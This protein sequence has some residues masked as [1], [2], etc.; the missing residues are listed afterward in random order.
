ALDLARGATLHAR[1]HGSDGSVL[2]ASVACPRG[3]VRAGA[4]ERAARSQRSR[5][6]VRRQRRDVALRPPRTW[7]G[8]RQFRAAD[9]DLTPGA[10]LRGA[11]A[12]LA[13]LISNLVC[14]A[15]LAGPGSDD[16]ATDGLDEVGVADLGATFVGDHHA[17]LPPQR[18]DLRRQ[19]EA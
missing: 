10:I 16:A 18:M 19:L 12:I 17:R 3:S 14:R 5:A 8:S 13:L 9:A 6:K 7:I 11:P 4:R 15:T 2:E 1:G